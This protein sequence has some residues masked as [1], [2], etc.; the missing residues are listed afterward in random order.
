M[1]IPRPQPVDGAPRLPDAETSFFFGQIQKLASDPKYE[2]DRYRLEHPTMLKILMRMLTQIEEATVLE[3]DAE[4]RRRESGLSG[5]R[6]GIGGGG[7]AALTSAWGVGGSGSEKPADHNSSKNTADKPKKTVDMISAC[8]EILCY[9][10]RNSEEARNGFLRDRGLDR[11]FRVLLKAEKPNEKVLKIFQALNIVM[12]AEQLGQALV[13]SLKTPGPVSRENSKE[14]G[15]G[16]AGSASG[17]GPASAA[18]GQQPSAPTLLDICMDMADPERDSGFHIFLARLLWSVWEVEVVTEFFV[19]G[20]GL[21]L[22][23]AL[24]SVQ[25]VLARTYV[26]LLLA[27]LLADHKLDDRRRGSAE[28]GISALIQ[29]LEGLVF[30]G[31]IRSSG[32]ADRGSGGQQIREQANGT[33]P[34][35]VASSGAAGASASPVS[36]TFSAVF[37]SVEKTE[38]NSAVKSLIT[39]DAEEANLL[40]TLLAQDNYLSSLSVELSKMGTQPSALTKIHHLLASDGNVVAAKLGLYVLREAKPKPEHFAKFYDVVRPWAVHERPQGHAEPQVVASDIFLTM[41]SHPPKLYSD[42]GLAGA[43]KVG[44]GW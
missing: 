17:G 19:E 20:L 41:T 28:A 9:S 6:G 36:S 29:E 40:A 12:G 3:K 39:T 32:L 27:G 31:Q 24:F 43:D 2:A 21:S 15:G 37:G 5:G 44:K 25:S 13:T 14:L 34:P 4:S 38:E 35:S 42:E 10:L 23:S 16:G 18:G 30:F 11:L 8:S 26:G 7:L 33:G 1:T 22:L